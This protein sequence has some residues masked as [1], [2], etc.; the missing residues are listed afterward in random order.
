MMKKLRPY[1]LFIPGIFLVTG[2]FT[3]A[4]FPDELQAKFE[5]WFKRYPVYTVRMTFNQPEYVPGD[6]IR[7]SAWYLKDDLSPVS[8]DQLL[9]ADLVNESGNTVQRIR[10][11]VRDGRGGNQIILSENLDAGIYSIYGYSDWMRNFGLSSLFRAE[12]KVSGK[13]IPVR[14]Q[15]GR[16][17]VKFFPEGGT[18]I[19]GVP[20]RVAVT[21]A[22][23]QKIEITDG[24][25]AKVAA[26]SLD[27][28]GLG[29]VLLSPS[30][31]TSYKV[32]GAVASVMPSVQPSGIS[33]RIDSVR[34][35]RLNV[36][37]MNMDAGA[38]Y[39]I[40]ALRNGKMVF[41]Q[42]LSFGADGR[43]V[44]DV[45]VPEG[46]TEPVAAYVF[47]GK[48]TL[49]SSRLFATAAVS[50]AGI[51]LRF[52]GEPVQKDSVGFFLTLPAE[53]NSGGAAMVSVS[54]IQENLFA[55]GSNGSGLAYGRLPE[56]ASW[57]ADHRI[58]DKAKLNDFLLTQSLPVVDWSA[59]WSDRQPVITFDRDN[60]LRLR[61]TAKG[62]TGAELPDSTLVM[63]YLLNNA[64]G[65]E[66]YTRNGQFNIPVIFD[67]YNGDKVFF[68][69][70][71]SKAVLH[72]SVFQ[73]EEDSLRVKPFYKSVPSGQVSAYSDYALK[74]NIVNRSYGFFTGK[75]GEATV[76]SPNQLLEEEFQGADYSIRVDE[77][78]I[79]PTME[80]FIREV[81]AFVQVRKR[82]GIPAARVYY[83]IEKSIQYYDFDPL[84]VIDGVMSKDPADLLGLDPRE[85]LSIKVISNPNKLSQLG[86]LG[87]NG[88]ILVE[89]K[90]GNLAARLQKNIFPTVGLNAPAA[91]SN[92]YRLKPGIPVM[93]SNIYW[94]PDV[95]LAP[96]IAQKFSFRA[97]DDSGP[98]LMVIQGISSDGRPFHQV[99]RFEVG[100]NPSRK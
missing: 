39:F 17:E 49:L 40:V 3:F 71:S 37:R 100:R 85:L 73:L 63:S 89:S 6:T 86:R 83:R 45:P 77:Y 28:S 68:A 15:A 98:M 55:E 41:R 44:V 92:L 30:A 91:A 74:R 76:I 1:L 27:K 47:D 29:S 38:D 84:L 95:R 72:G 64:A 60:R 31:G 82:N 96:G 26:V 78:V 23:G 16:I 69:A 99:E 58:T 33:I 32:A 75:S 65:Y 50:D 79:F 51:R 34:S 67:Y 35:S 12:V 24:V 36:V 2:A 81:V 94:N 14:Q 13:Y 93:K 42:Q 53:G 80:E 54:V 46:S 57:A 52:A 7:F 62:A 90:K 87:E 97:S 56:W 22:P 9:R 19:A 88:V 59:I 43:A 70:R 61:G 20:T 10:F 21:G 4:Y 18:L 11:R 48:A 66:G 25:G 5:S 8:G